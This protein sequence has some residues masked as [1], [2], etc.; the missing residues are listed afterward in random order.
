MR[1]FTHFL[2]AL[3]LI[4]ILAV[5]LYAQ[6]SSGT[7]LGVVRDAQATVVPNATVT[8]TN[9]ATN[10]SKSFTTG[11]DG[12]YVVPFLEPGEYSVSAE[13]TGFKKTTR[14]GIIVRVG[15]KLT[16][17]LGLEVG[18]ITEQV[19]VESAAPLVDFTN[20]TLGQVIENR[21]IQELPLNGRDAFSLAGLAPGVVPVQPA[22][23][24]A[25]QLGNTPPSI[26][27]AAAGTS[28]ITID[29]IPDTVP[30]NNTYLLTYIPSVDTVEE[31]KVQTN[32]LSA[33][34]GRYNGGVISVVTKSGTNA[35][36]GTLY[37]FHRNSYFDANNFFSN[38]NKIPLGAL[39]RNQF[40]ATLGGPVRIPK[41]YNGKDRTFFFFNYEGFRESALNVGTFTVPTEAQRRGDFSQTRNAAGQLVQIFDPATTR[42]NPSGGF[43]RDAFA[44][45]VI[46]ASR[47]SPAAAR[48]LQYY[49]LP[50]NN[51]LTGNLVLSVPRK[52]V[53]DI[54]DARI[55]HGVT[56]AL[57]VF[58]RFSLQDPTVGEPNFFG[59]PGNPTN[60]PL[61]QLRRSFTFQGIYTASPTLLVS[62][63][64]GLSRQFG[65]RRA[66]SDGL[67]I[68]ELGF[69]ANFRDAQQAPAVPV[70][71]ITG[72]TGLGNGVQNFSTQTG[73]TFL[74]TVTNIRG[75]HTF[76]AGFDY[77]AYY[78]NQ[79]QNGQASGNLSFTQA[80]TQGPNPNQ[81]SAAAGLGFATFLLGLP[82]GTI[83]TRPATA[84]KSSYLAGFLQDDWKFSPRL[85]LNLGL[86]YEVSVPRTERYDR[87]NVFDLDV[88]SPIAGRVAAFPNLKGAVIN[89]DAD[90]RRLVETDRNNFGP[91][92]GLAF[93][94]FDKTTVRAGYGV[95]YGLSATDASLSGAFQ[96]GFAAQTDIISSLDGVTPIVALANQFPSGINRPRTAAEIGPGINLGLGISSAALLQ[97]TSYFQQWNLSVQQGIGQSL[98]LEIAY[99]GN[100]GTR[101]NLP[102]ALQL[103]G[104]TAE[105]TA[106]GAANQQLV[107]NPFFGVI[108]DPTSALSRA[109]VTRGQLLR[110]FP[111]YT[112]VTAEFP[113][114]GNLI[115]HAL[116]AKVEKRFARGYT[117]LGAY[118]WSKNI[119]D[120]TAAIQ[121]PFN[122][123]AERSLDAS[124]APHRL[125]LSGIVELPIG[126]GRLIGKNWNRALEAALG[127]WQLN[128]IAAFQSGFPLV[129]SSTGVA[130]PNRVKQGDQPTNRVQDRL[131]RYFDT[132]AFAVPAAFTY[133][134]SSRTH[135]DIRAHGINNFDLSLFKIF[136]I[137]EG[138]KAQFRFET[139]NAF[140]RV[141][142][143]A[144]G[145]QTGTAAFG[146]IT[147][148][149]NSPRQLQVALKLIF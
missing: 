80:F 130:R 141:Q 24:A 145:T 34:H 11:D 132:S 87:I 86:R 41:L 99:A 131:D 107:T 77:R 129:I 105:Q 78:N 121:D 76:K 115:Y 45:N 120:L 116:Q 53:S 51:N 112:S 72:F 5:C 38:K 135:G 1:Y 117:L 64:Y 10:I 101:I 40:G 21:R 28:E 143:A 17:D 55:D 82:G 50:N 84:F 58:G 93:Q 43:I 42:A 89:R 85:T 22:P 46:P 9:V 27:G 66:W 19:R 18:A 108:T 68:T 12:A 71:T 102:S 75:A 20:T 67:D 133:G 149:Q 128:G 92:L 138:F 15:D 110:P 147:N 137:T 2:S 63:Q 56:S 95:F 16:V 26:S 36:H 109:T 70:T 35:F 32:A 6:T 3:R 113:A 57:K 25:I 65:T 97:T 111:Q 140:N 96:E 81:A 60:P 52:N 126:R 124:D 127:G 14:A 91:R 144:P 62:L 100:K 37:E 79:L 148:Q 136:A 134:N 146:V 122:L 74:G 94:A 44:N 125:V 98:L 49:P 39:R 54:Y 29:G 106:L 23:G 90:N 118:T 59:T 83:V 31:F 69:A 4:P 123:R 33:E 88:P 73:H 30:R 104:L 103:N 8:V 139:F 61:Q 13:A 114:L 119:N 47:I 48:M 7:I 142:F